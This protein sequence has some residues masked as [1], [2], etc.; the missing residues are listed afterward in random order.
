MEDSVLVVP[1]VLPLDVESFKLLS[2]NEK[3][4]VN[5]IDEVAWIGA[6]I[7]L[8]QL[9]PESAGIFLLSH[10]IF[11]LQDA[12]DIRDIA[13]SNGV[14]AEDIDA[15]VAYFA[16]IYGNLGNYLSFGNTKFIPAVNR[17]AFTNIVNLTDAYKSSELVREIFKRVIDSIYSTHPGCLRLSFPQEGM[18]TYYSANCTRSDAELVQTFLDSRRIEAYNT[19]LMKKFDKDA[20]GRDNYELLVASADSGEEEIENA[21]LSQSSTL[22]IKYG[23]YKELM[24]LIVS[25]IDV[26]KA[27]ALNDEQ[28]KM[29]SEY[30]RSFQTGS[31]EAHKAGSKHWV[32]DEKPTVESYIGFIETY[33]DPYGVRG[34]FETFVAVVDKNVSAKCQNLVKCASLFLAL[35]PWPPSYETDA[36]LEPD[37]TSLDIMS[38][39]VSG[40]PAG[41]N[42][43][44]YDDI[45]QSIGFKN[46]S[47]GN[48]LKANFQVEQ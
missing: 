9:S 24:Q 29:W 42:I 11:Q 26:I 37:F 33:R 14:R 4:Y 41:I 6:L 31:I 38:F 39:G 7:D 47:L 8:I 16:S 20:N 35:L 5:A 19:R 28:R 44:N 22:K 10:N 30:Q 46:V 34:E 17:E 48:I 27:A 45:R 2:K 43:P 12:S 15:F 25:G 18:T 21:G 23:D 32:A 13:K 3:Q 36:F 40:L 1:D